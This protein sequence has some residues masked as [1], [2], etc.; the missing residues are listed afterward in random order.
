M[1]TVNNFS[2]IC[3]LF[4]H[5]QNDN[6]TIQNYNLLKKNNPTKNVYSIGFENHNL[7]DGSHI[8]YRNQLYP[9]NKDLNSI[10]KKE[11]WS[12]ADLLIYD[13]YINNSN[14]SKYLVIEWDTYCN[15][16]LE[17]FYGNSLN[18]SNFSHGIAEK[19]NLE[20]W[21]WYTQL[22]DSQKLIHNIGGI[23]PTSGLFF[24]KSVL[25]SM[26]DLMINNPR[27]YDNMFSEL[28]LGTLLQ[29]SGYTL[30]KPFL[31]SESYINWNI[32]SIT[33]DPSKPGYY[34][35]IKTIV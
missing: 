30:N 1:E 21:H 12:E 3:I 7:I 17:D 20:N 13:F 32:D 26:V 2:E 10:C 6:V 15:C 29:Q 11:Y 14:A 28:R 25:S 27:Q 23:G 31:N 24:T 4:L 8:V 9:Q 35:P 5:Y 16:S 19:E 18:M 34:H 22:S 33:F